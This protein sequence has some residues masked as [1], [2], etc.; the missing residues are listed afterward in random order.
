MVHYIHFVYVNKKLTLNEKKEDVAI[1]KTVSYPLMQHLISSWDTRL[2]MVSKSTIK[3]RLS[4]AHHIVF[5][6]FRIRVIE[7]STLSNLE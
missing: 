4:H 7:A 1:L 3:F 2:E 5:M 6:I